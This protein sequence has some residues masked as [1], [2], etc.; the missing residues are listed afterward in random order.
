VNHVGIHLDSGRSQGVVARKGDGKMHR[1]IAFDGKN[2][3]SLCEIVI[4]N[5][6]F[7]VR[8]WLGLKLGDIP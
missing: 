5:M 6:E 4:L 2:Q 7:D 3:A 8:V 1:A